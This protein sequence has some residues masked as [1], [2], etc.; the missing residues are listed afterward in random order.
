M[1]DLCYH[2]NLGIGKDFEP[3][4]ER[5][6]KL[7]PPVY[8]RLNL[9]GEGEEPDVIN[10]QP[11]WV[12]SSAHWKTMGPRLTKF[13]AAGEAFLF[14]RNTELPFPNSSVDSVFSNSVP[15]DTTTWLGPGVQSSEVRR[16]LRSGGEW[17]DNGI[18][19]YRKP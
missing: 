1:L 19:V 3:C 4:I 2:G 17:Q 9:G 6:G 12:T 18:V 13:I 7:A 14:C 5:S 8:F 11:E 15:I 16:V 10:Q